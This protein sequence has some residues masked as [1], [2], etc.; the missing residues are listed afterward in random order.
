MI[1]W[2]RDAAAADGL[3]GPVMGSAGFFIFIFLIYRG[4]HEKP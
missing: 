2:R 1:Q 4:G 3:A